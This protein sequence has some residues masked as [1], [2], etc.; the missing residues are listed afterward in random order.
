MTKG[1]IRGW[2]ATLSSNSS[3]KHP[4]DENPLCVYFGDSFDSG[5]L[6]V[7]KVVFWCLFVWG[8]P[9][10]IGAKGLGLLDLLRGCSD[11]SH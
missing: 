1:R 11:I 3:A 6:S 10:G 7:G 8:V 9:G 4:D 5:W 2:A